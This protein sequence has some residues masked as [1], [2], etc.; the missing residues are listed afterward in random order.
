M[1]IYL[2]TSGK[3]EL[4]RQFDGTELTSVVNTSDVNVARK[5]LS[6]DFQRGQLITGDQI[7]ITSTNGAALS[8]IDSYTK[9]SV[10]KYINVDGIGGIRLYDNFADAINGLIT[11][12]TT[13]AAPASNIPIR[14]AVENSDFR[15]LAQVKGFELNTQRETVDTTTLSEEFRSQLSTLMSGSGSMTCF[16]EYTGERTNDLPQYLLNLILRTKVGSHFRGKFYLKAATGNA[17]D[18]NDEIWY[19]FEGVLTAC[20]LQFT[21]DEAVEITADFIT[22]GAIDLR[23]VLTPTSALLQEDGDDIRLDQ[24]GAA[25][26]L[27]ESTET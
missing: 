11:N 10:K 24:D 27:L 9:T 3:I 16:W 1:S 17:A 25:K 26:L 18:L 22:T 5:R 19:E 13:L 2:G 6:F 23:A 15:L 8:F 7:E 12:A 21:P 20:A 4:L 14:V